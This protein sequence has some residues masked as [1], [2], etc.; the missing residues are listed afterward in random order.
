VVQV[1]ALALDDHVKAAE[2]DAYADHLGKIDALAQEQRREDQDEYR[3]A[4]EQQGGEARRHMHFAV[5]EQIVGNAEVRQGHKHEEPAAFPG[6]Q[7]RLTAHHGK[8]QEQRKRDEKA[9]AGGCQRR[10]ALDGDLDAQ[11]RG[12]PTQAHDQEHHA[13]HQPGEPLF[14][15]FCFCSVFENG[16]HWHRLLL[17]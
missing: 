17:P 12:A 1:Q 5:V 15:R 3:H 9:Q 2:T 7:D 6:K 8:T 11:P 4:T 13:G 16:G 10:H 14:L